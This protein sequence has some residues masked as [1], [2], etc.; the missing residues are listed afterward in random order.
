[1]TSK[2]ELVKSNDLC[3]CSHDFS[4]H[5]RKIGVSPYVN[6]GHTDIA[7]IMCTCGD[8]IPTPYTQMTLGF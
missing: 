5:T 6:S 2:D 7:C 4:E 1:M 8:Y 3:K